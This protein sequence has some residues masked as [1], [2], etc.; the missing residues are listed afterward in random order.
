MYKIYI[1]VI[2]LFPFL[3]YRQDPIG[4][5]FFLGGWCSP[6]CI[7]Y[8]GNPHIYTTY[9]FEDGIWQVFPRGIGPICTFD[10]RVGWY[11]FS[12]SSLLRNIGSL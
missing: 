9:L 5:K 8:I 11:C 10:F 7:P 2:L 4:I 6:L 1:P 3:G 12:S